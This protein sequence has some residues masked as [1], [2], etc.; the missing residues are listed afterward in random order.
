M[1]SAVAI[2]IESKKQCSIL[3]VCINIDYK[4]T[5]FQWNIVIYATQKKKT[6]PKLP[7]YSKWNKRTKNFKVKVDNESVYNKHK[8]KHHQQFN[9]APESKST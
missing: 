4:Y 2:Y 6:A 1:E 3:L 7:F 8:Y 9:I 5:I